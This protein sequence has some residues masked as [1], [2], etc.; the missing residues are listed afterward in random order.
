MV[1]Q[2]NANNAEIKVPT[3]GNPIIELKPLNDENS[4]EMKSLNGNLVNCRINNISNELDFIDN[5]V[6]PSRE[7]KNGSVPEAQQR[8]CNKNK[9]EVSVNS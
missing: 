6:S 3:Q 8:Q 4:C 2:I 9:F 1:Q 5:N 7:V